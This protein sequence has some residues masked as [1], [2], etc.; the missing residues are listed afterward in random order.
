MHISTL[1]LPHDCPLVTHIVNSYGKNYLKEKNKH[2]SSSHRHGNTTPKGSGEIAMMRP[3]SRQMYG[4]QHSC[5]NNHNQSQSPEKQSEQSI[6]NIMTR[7]GRSKHQQ[8]SQQNF[9][10]PRNSASGESQED[11][12]SNPHS[13]DAKANRVLPSQVI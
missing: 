13:T 6:I 11:S 3:K 1:F 9:S 8:P 10:N 5:S 7:L 12:G 4:Q 2:S